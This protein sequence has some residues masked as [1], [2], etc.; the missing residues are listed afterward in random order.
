MKRGE[1]DPARL[2]EL[3]AA[4]A[5][6][7]ERR[8]IP[9]LV[10]LVALGD[11]IHVRATGAMRI[12]DGA[13]MHRDTIFRIAS[14]AKPIA[15][16][17]TMMLVDDGRLRL[18]DAVDR[19]LPELANRRVLRHI[20]AEL[21]DTVLADR[22]IV[23]RDLLASTF[24]FGSVM[25]MPE[26][27]PIQEPIRTGHLGGD[28]PPKYARWP[29]PEEWMRR[30]G[31][32]PLMYQPGERF[33]YNTSSDVLGVLIARLSGKSFGTF[34]RERLFEP[35]AMR[36]TAFFVPPE[37]IDRLAGL[38]RFDSERDAFEAFESVAD[39][40]YARP[41]TFESGSGGLVSTA[42]DYFAFCRMLLDGGTRGRERILSRDAVE[43]MTRDQLTPAQ[44]LGAEVFFGDHGTWGFGIGVDI[45]RERPWMVP[46]RFGW[47]GGFG[48]AAYSDPENDFVGILMTQRVLDSP[49]PPAVFESFW[50]HAYR[51]LV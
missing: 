9:G 15:A 40:E 49:E 10:T 13:P 46:G 35:L 20:G 25:A 5:E 42:D 22:P 31:A 33:L 30:L 27:Y 18:D 3:D 50:E 32:L 37:K 12:D 16:A 41:P 34:L 14:L 21:D 8:D 1:L 36:D 38:Y 24:G 51:A 28:G 47:V 7:V 43:A 23:V 11:D 2:A 19:W 6:L 29:A 45:K 44:R 26:T 39:G 4:M 17:A 48:T